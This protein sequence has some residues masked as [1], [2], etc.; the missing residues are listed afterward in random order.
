MT[1]ARVE[2]RHERRVNDD[3]REELTYGVSWR[4]AV[5][6]NGELIS[7]DADPSPL[8]E[9]VG[10]LMKLF[11]AARAVVEGYVKGPYGVEAAELH[12][13]MAHGVI[14]EYVIK[15]GGGRD[16]REDSIL[17]GVRASVAACGR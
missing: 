5:Y 11:E 3:G 9:A 10:A 2:L 6:L 4:L 12:I 1:T 15:G 8:F 17:A 13:D 14:A 16:L 7:I